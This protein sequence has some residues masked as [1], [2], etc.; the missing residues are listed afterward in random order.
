[1]PDGS[2]PAPDLVPGALCWAWL[3]PTV[4]REQGGRRPVVV[5]SSHEYLTV[6]DT[7]AMVVP[8]TRTDRGWDNHIKV[9]VGAVSGWAMTEQVRTLSRQRIA[10]VVGVVD[11]A[12]FGWIRTWIADF[13]GLSS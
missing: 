11:T 7:L 5:V 1:M 12:A 10:E 13:L 2:T 9:S 6:V 8:V 4:G 3:D